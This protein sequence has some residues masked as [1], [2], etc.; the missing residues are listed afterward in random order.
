MASF[1]S[2]TG[3]ISEEGKTTFPNVRMVL[4][5]KWFEIMFYCR[6]SIIAFVINFQGFCDYLITSQNSLLRFILFNHSISLQ[7]QQY[8]ASIRLLK[9]N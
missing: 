9:C 3:V 4:T 1:C 6:K 5:L 7:F 2:I 8:I